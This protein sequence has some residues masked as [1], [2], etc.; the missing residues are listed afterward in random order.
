MG[1]VT[2]E[3]TSRTTHGG[4]DHPRLDET[5]EEVTGEGKHKLRKQKRSTRDRLP[6]NQHLY[7]NHAE[8]TETLCAQWAGHSITPQQ[9][10]CAN[11]PYLAAQH[12]QGASGQRTNCG[13]WWIGVHIDQ[14]PHL[15]QSSILPRKSKRNFER[16]KL[17]WFP[18]TTMTTHPHN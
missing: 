17:A 11:G 8:N 6:T 4:L 9:T 14:Q 12:K 15:K 16:N 18:G 2:N 7:L 1:N 3:S 10:S 5:N 13:K